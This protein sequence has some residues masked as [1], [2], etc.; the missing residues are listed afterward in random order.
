MRYVD[1]CAQDGTPYD[2]EMPK[3]TAKGRLIWVRSIGEAMRDEEGNIIGV[4]G[5]F[6]DITARKQV[7]A[8]REK[9]IKE[10]QNALAE[11]RTLQ[12]FLPICS[13]CRKVRDDANYWSQIES[14]ISEHTHTKFSHSIC[15]DCYEQEV[16]PQLEKLKR[17]TPLDF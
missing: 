12:E 11:V 3:Y 9:L 2:F 16:T 7:E 15:P 5:A 17:Q 10:L 1:N 6:Q 4:Q 8:E 13:Y 14:Y